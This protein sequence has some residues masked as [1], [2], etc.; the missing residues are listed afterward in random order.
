MRT[1]EEDR[2]TKKLIEETVK[3]T[4][5]GRDAEKACFIEYH[6]PTTTLARKEELKTA[7]IKSN[8]RFVLKLAKDYKKNTGMPINDF[9][10]EGKLGLLEA[11]NKYDYKLGV[12]FGSFAVWEIRRHMDIVV[13]NSDLVH[14]PVRM[15]KRVL[16]AKKKGES[17]DNVTYAGL[18]ENAVSSPVSLDQ[19]VSSDNDRQMTT[20]GDTVASEERTDANH[21]AEML[22]NSIFSL[23]SDTLS[24]EENNLLRRIYGFDGYEDTVAE[25]AAE[26]EISK[27]L[28]R[29][30]KNAALAKLR[31][32]PEFAILRESL[33]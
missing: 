8:L 31:K 2:S 13:Q 11:F 5:L 7:I 9:Y 18:A 23:M 33:E 12:K 4:I 30:A 10:S 24:P 22:R 32:R 21:E 16:K 27:E 19:P 17:L 6:R 25:I 1:C 29:R 14:V 15:R 3:Y 28:I 26:K 20:V